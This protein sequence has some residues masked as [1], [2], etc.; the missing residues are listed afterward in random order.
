MENTELTLRYGCNPHQKPA[1]V[2]SKQGALPFQVLSGAPGYINLLDALNSWQLVRELRS[3][4]NLPAATSFKHVSP[5][6]AAVGVPLDDRLKQAYAVEDLELSPL[7]TAY[8]RARGADRQA[9]YG[10]FAAL[11]D[12]VDVSTAKLI[13]REVSDGVIAPGFEP[14]ALEILRKKRKGSYIVLQIDPNYEPGEMETREVFGVTFEQKRNNVVPTFEMLKD[15][16]TRNKNLS[17]AAQRDMVLSLITLKYTQSNS[18]CFAYDGQAIGI[19][20]GGQSRIMCTRA[21]AAKAENWYLRL[22]P[23]ALSLPFKAGVKRQEKVNAVDT[24]LRDDL[25]AIEEKEWEQLFDAVPP[26]L[27]TQEKEEWL[28]GLKGVTLGSD[29]YIPF[30]DSIDCAARYGVSYVIQPGASMRDEDV[31]Q[32]CDAYDIAMAMAGIRLFH[33]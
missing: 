27:T 31:I 9:S 32:A 20:A 10:D 26:R 12:I 24:Y 28:S 14:E 23:A 11:S 17:E 8:A 5:A 15:V 3:S 16:P 4:L 22:H 7:A 25:T 33:H 1:R 29:G 18:I 6:G 30:R 2:Y 13:S 19:G 21:A